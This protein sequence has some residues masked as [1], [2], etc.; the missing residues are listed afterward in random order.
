[1]WVRIHAG[2]KVNPCLLKRPLSRKML[3]AE[4]SDFE[5]FYVALTDLIKRRR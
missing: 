4:D 2:I 5:E 3:K 1:M